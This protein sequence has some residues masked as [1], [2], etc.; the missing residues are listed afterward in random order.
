MNNQE[1]ILSTIKKVYA[2]RQSVEKRASENNPFGGIPVIGDITFKI[3]GMSLSRDQQK[4]IAAFVAASCMDEVAL[5]SMQRISEYKAKAAVKR[6]SKVWMSYIGLILPIL[7]VIMAE[8]YMAMIGVI[9]EM[10]YLIGTFVMIIVAIIVSI[11]LFAF[12]GYDPVYRRDYVESLVWRAISEE[13]IKR[14]KQ[15]ANIKKLPAASG[16]A[17]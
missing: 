10:P 4:D 1:L 8:A 12:L 3:S 13:C 2:I 14:S 9:T 5:K 15:I 17:Q 11:V 16:T 7:I 6:P